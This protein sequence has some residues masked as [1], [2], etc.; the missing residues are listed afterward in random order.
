MA[1]P[2]IREKITFDVNTPQVI[3]LTQYTNGREIAGR[4]GQ[5]DYLYWLTDNRSLFAPAELH[6]AIQAYAP[7]QGESFEITKRKRGNARATW[8][9]VQLTDEEPPAQEPPAR[10]PQP[11]ARPAAAE[12]AKPAASAPANTLTK[13]SLDLVSCFVSAIDALLEAQAYASKRGLNFR[14]DS[15]DIRATAISAYISRCK[16]GN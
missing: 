4:D 8:E 6:Q 11:Q 5:T 15:G 13:S 14:F 7:K 3:T 9:V 1:A 2:S 16:G 12:P 10:A